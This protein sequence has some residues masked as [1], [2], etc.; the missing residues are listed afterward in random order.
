[1]PG[2]RQITVDPSPVCQVTRCGVAVA[3]T[4]SP[5]TAAV[6]RTG[7]HGP[8]SHS[9]VGTCTSCSRPTA[10]LAWI[11]GEPSPSCDSAAWASTAGAAA[12]PAA[13]GPAPPGTT[14]G[15]TQTRVK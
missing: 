8:A 5:G 14:P 11:T 6:A 13:A 7:A 10:G 2:P 9:Q 12:A 1:M 15:V 4:C 3:V